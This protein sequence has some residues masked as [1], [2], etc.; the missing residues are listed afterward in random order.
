MYLVQLHAIVGLIVIASKT[1]FGFSCNLPKKNY[2]FS[3]V[4]FVY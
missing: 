4:Q 1:W 2:G 3:F